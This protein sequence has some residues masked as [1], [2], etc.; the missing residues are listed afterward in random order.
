MRNPIE[1]WYHQA[2]NRQ[3]ENKADSIDDYCYQYGNG[4]GN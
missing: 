4:I 1:L 3:I 2:A